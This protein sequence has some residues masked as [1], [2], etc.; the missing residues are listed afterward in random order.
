MGSEVKIVIPGGSGFLGT[1]L[2][3]AFVKRGDEVVVLSRTPRSHDYRSVAW[4]G[5]T[6]GAWTREVDGADVVINLAGRSVHCRYNARNR[7]EIL[8]S[9][10]RSVRVVGQAIARATQPPRIWLQAST[11][12]IYAHRYDAP[13]DELS[14]ILGGS[15]PGAP[16]TWRF[17]IDVARAWESALDDVDLPRTRKVAMRTAMVMGPD[18]DSGAMILKRLAAFGLGGHAGDGRQY[19]SWIHQDDFVR[20]VEWLIA[21]DDLS[22]AVNITSPFPLTNADFMRDL[23]GAVGIPVGLPATSWMVE[24]G[25][26]ALRTESELILKSRRV[27]PTRLLRS[28]FT[29]RFP[30]WDAAA[31]DLCRRPTERDARVAA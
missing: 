9:R 24:V 11:A 12:T 30:R 6:L 14:G 18:P 10:V 2:A 17:S 1:V 27:I 29:F 26:F 13:N 23:R 19:M 31:R 21:H 7:R 5:E 28:G 8:E 22:G 25:S 20:A 3:R 15:E 4:N 16:D